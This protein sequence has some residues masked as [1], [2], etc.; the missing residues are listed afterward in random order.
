MTG[1]VAEQ[2][3]R[4]AGKWPHMG[5][6]HAERNKDDSIVVVAWGAMVQI[7][8]IDRGCGG[9]SHPGSSGWRR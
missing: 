4:C 8:V 9:V 1:R 5:G 7:Q 2:R 3:P 6:N